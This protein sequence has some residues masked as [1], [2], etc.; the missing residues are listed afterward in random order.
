MYFGMLSNGVRFNK[1][2][3]CLASNSYVADLVTPRFLSCAT[4]CSSA[5][6]C[7]L[8]GYTASS[9]TCRLSSYV[10]LE[11]NN[12]CIE[13][14]EVHQLIGKYWHETRKSKRLFG[15]IIGHL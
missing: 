13:G 12:T 8:F 11:S 15:I 6:G 2:S 10:E 14:E 1:S 5:P 4:N 7:K 3:K 9:K